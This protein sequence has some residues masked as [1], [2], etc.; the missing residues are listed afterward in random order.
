MADG[1]GKKTGKVVVWILLALLIVGLAGFGIGSFGGAASTVGRVG[2]RA[3]TAQ[4]YF[5]ALDQALRAE[6]V[7][8][9]VAVGRAEAEAS[10]LIQAVQLQ[11]AAEAALDGETASLGL[12]VGDETVGA[13][14]LSQPGFVGPSGEFDRQAY[15]FTLRQNGWSVPAFEQDV[16]EETARSILQGA[17]AGGAAPPDPL[18]DTLVNFFGETRSFTWRRLDAEDLDAALPAPTDADLR[19]QYEAAPEAYTLPEAK[20]ITYVILRPEAVSDT[21]EADDTALRALYERR[22]DD[23][24]QPERRLVERLVFESEAAAQEAADA[25]NAGER[26]FAE[27]VAARDLTLADID[28]GDVSR[29]EL[30]DA[31]EQVFAMEA[32]GIVGPLPS[33]FGPALFRMNAILDARNLQLEDVRDMLEQEVTI[34]RARRLLD[35]LREEFDDRLAAGATLE[36]LAAESEMEIGQ[37]DYYPGVEADIAGYETFRTAADAVTLDD[38]PEIDVLGDGSLYALRLDEVVPPTLQPLDEIR[39]TVTEDWR[40]AETVRRLR[41][42]GAQIEAQLAVGTPLEGTGPVERADAVGRDAFLDGVPAELTAEAFELDEGESALVE[43]DGLLYVMV[44]EEISLP[45][46]G[47]PET[48]PLRDA[49]TQQTAQGIASDL[50]RFYQQALINR[51]G[52]SFEP[53]GLN[54]IHTQVFN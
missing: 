45:E 24:V 17:V 41:T 5:R 39:A 43:G 48:D 25:I 47:D 51:E 35:E 49:I 18:V 29:E 22:I 50:L 11:L 21:L 38:F 28:L 34:E 40:A 33:P 36:D 19:A 12:S 14:I 26:S 30:G 2:D 53:A 13:Q 6:R 27:V 4:D 37:I 23:F 10:G 52:I 1:I 54:A 31:A 42:L 15:E 3:I 7:S 9:G 44:L 16:R 20:R 46:E 32:P 8:R